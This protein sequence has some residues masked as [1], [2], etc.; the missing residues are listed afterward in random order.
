MVTWTHG[1]L[2]PRKALSAPPTNLQSACDAVFTRLAHAGSRQELLHCASELCFLSRHLDRLIDSARVEV[3]ESQEILA[4]RAALAR[5]RRDLVEVMPAS[6][7]PTG[8][9][10]C[11]A[12]MRNI[13][14][15]VVADLRYGLLVLHWARTGSRRRLAR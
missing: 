10:R 12:R 5:A 7:Y 2:A 13:L 15:D 8:F 11:H 9:Y 1:I 6:R 3:G 4:A 14:Y